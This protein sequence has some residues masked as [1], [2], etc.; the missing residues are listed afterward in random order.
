MKKTLAIILCLI[1]VL[2]VMSACSDKEEPAATSETKTEAKTQSEETTEPA[3]DEDEGPITEL[4]LPL[5]EESVKLTMWAG[6]SS[7]AAASIKNY[8]EML[9]YQELQNR[10]GIEIEFIHP[11]VGQE[12]EQFNLMLASSELTDLIHYSWATD[13][14]GGPEKAIS[15]GVILELSDYMNNYSPNFTQIVNDNSQVAKDA[16]TDNGYFYMYPLLRLDPASRVSGGFQIRKDWLDK[17]GMDIPTNMD[18][19]YEVLT[20]FK[21]SD[22]N[23][24]GEDDEIPFIATMIGPVNGVQRFTTAWGIG[25]SYYVEDGEVKF[26]PAQP[27]YKEYLETMRKWYQEGLI[28]PDFLNT[29]RKT[30]DAKVTSEVAGSYY[31]LLNSYMGNYTG[32]LMEQNPEAQLV[33]VPAPVSPDGKQYNFKNDECSPVANE[34]I[35]ITSMNEYPELS[36]QLLDYYYSEDGRIL[37]NL[38]IEGT[39]FTMVDGKPQYTEMITANEDGLSIDRAA[40]KYMPVG[41]AARLYQDQRYWDQ[42][43]KYDNQRS[44][45]AI[46]A[47]ASTE[48]T[49]PPITPTPEE[50]TTLSSIQNEI[51]TYVNEMFARFIMGQ[52]DISEFDNYISTLESLNLAEAL[53]INQKALE[54]YYNRGN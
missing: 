23:G 25:Y 22:L 38:G 40:A 33:E 35:A 48:K 39:T 3:A 14:V 7:R 4:T 17:V 24:N 6:L 13:Y 16:V 29:D 15:D 41:T 28:D 20:A 10:T 5:T 52:D 54:R 45:M 19:W 11:P 32:I 51:D 2:G 53:D 8:G 26:G 44:A 21:G 42:M 12:K 34:G 18:E 31:G 1:M 50:A 37:L 43:M 27:E 49:L 47:Q 46:L 9:A 30:H 36:A